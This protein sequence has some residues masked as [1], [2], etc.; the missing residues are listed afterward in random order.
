M[1]GAAAFSVAAYHT[2]HPNPYGYLA[3]DLFFMLSGFVLMHAYG[4]PDMNVRE[5]MITRAIRL[6]PMFIAG[7]LVGLAI[8]GGNPATILM[9]PD[10]TS[11]RPYPMNTALWSVGFEM[12]ASLGFAVLYRFGWKVWVLAFVV[13]AMAWL[14]IVASNIHASVGMHW[15]T[16]LIGLMRMTFAFCV[17]IALY[18]F[19]R[20][21]EWRGTSHFS[22]L[23][24][25][26]PVALGFLPSG[27]FVLA[28]ALLLAF[29]V[30]ILAGALVQPKGTRLAKFSG[31]IS[32]PLYAIHQPILVAYGW[33]AL[34]FVVLV[35]W[36]LDRY[37]DR[38]VRRT[39]SRFVRPQRPIE[40]WGKGSSA[41]RSLSGM[42]E[43][44]KDRPPSPTQETPLE[45]LNPTGRELRPPG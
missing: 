12:I 24:C 10:W 28:F 33:A 6:Y 31:D 8:R 45:C 13:S 17:G 19:Y 43:G 5:L 35:A 23:L 38:P 26:A 4:R 25:L 44:Q 42:G 2:G 15:E 9:I 16:V 18:W 1:R 32:Y 3:V 22:W 21:I 11:N 7:I 40:F 37:V 20:R 39:L 41:G 29:P 27:S 36:L 34:P 30:I 14:P